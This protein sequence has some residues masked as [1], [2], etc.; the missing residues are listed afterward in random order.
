[1]TSARLR[2]LGCVTCL[3][4]VLI[5]ASGRF[6]AQAPVWMISAGLAVIVLGWGLLIGSV[7]RRAA[8]ARVRNLKTD[9]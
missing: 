7:L 2:D 1:M 5:M 4:G 9:G 6:V 8:V 3:L